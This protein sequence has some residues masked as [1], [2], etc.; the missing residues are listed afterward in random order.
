MSRKPT[1]ETATGRSRLGFGSLL[2]LG[3]NGIV[4]VGIFYAPSELS[5]LLG[6]FASAWAFALTALLLVPVA[7]AY[8]RLGS[9][10]AEDGGPYVWARAALGERFAFG[11][12]FVA[13]C[14]AVLSTSAVV[15]G[16]GMYLGPALGFTSPVG[17]WV[18][19]ILAAC[20]LSGLTLLGLRPSAWVWSLLTVAKLVP[21]VLLA[22]LGARA[23]WAS[24]PAVDVGS[25][26][27]GSLTRAALF[28]VFPL[29]GF[30][31]VAVPAGA[32][33]SRSGQQ[34]RAVLAATL[35]SLLLA[36]LLYVLLQSAC[37]LAVP[38]LAESSAP[39][40]EA[41]TRLTGGAGRGLFSAGT[42]VSAVGI[43][44]GMF[45][46]TPRY[47]SALG[48]AGLFGV[49][50]SRERSG[51]P[52]L[53]TLVTAGAVLLLVSL[54]ALSSLLVLASLAVLLQYGVSAIALFIL[55]ARRERGLGRVDRVLAPLCLASLAL[56][57]R[58]AQL[59]ELV[60]LAGILV[61]GFAVLA[62][63]R[64][65]ARGASSG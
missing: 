15:F 4:G 11:V 47:L 40:V 30:E 55:A 44:F 58:S 43:A 16:L 13:Y 48:T 20:L 36:A 61:C 46:M 8:G 52:V 65:L 53:A 63:R 2:A 5:R 38:K 27:F 21:L 28:A 54:S 24:G 18:F 64:A 49:S 35:G 31:I 39:I 7:W 37:V 3:I 51:V 32:V 41:G 17:A 14:S 26:S 50:L 60:T 56:L 29:Q 62:L 59:V 25:L 1:F 57:V 12:G 22:V 23:L 45:A 9:A 19:R 33:G 10:F 6:G 42:N 34:S